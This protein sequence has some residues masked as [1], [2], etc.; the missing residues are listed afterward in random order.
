MLTL[1]SEYALRAMI[2]LTQHHDRGEDRPVFGKKIAR[3]IDVPAKY[4]SAIL[5]D[6]VRAGLLSSTRGKNGGFHLSIPAKNVTLFS[7]LAPFERVGPTRCPFGNTVCSDSDP[8]VAHTGWKK[9][10]EARL[11][12][13]SE[14]TVAQVAARELSA[15]AKQK[16]RRPKKAKSRS[17][18]KTSSRARAS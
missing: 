6:L 11:N 4:L 5:G 13:L 15:P 17:P 12:F 7:V 10:L 8:C 18:K 3:R 2:Y 1:T 14:T 9:V 16:A